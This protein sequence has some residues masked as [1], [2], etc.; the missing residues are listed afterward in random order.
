VAAKNKVENRARPGS[1][2]WPEPRPLPLPGGQGARWSGE[3]W[4]A[5]FGSPARIREWAAA[6]LATGRLLPWFAV[7]YGAGVVLYFSA[8]REPALWAA[9]VPTVVCAFVAVLLQRRIV[10]RNFVLGVI[11][12]GLFGIALG[13]AVVTLKTSLIGHPVLRFPASGVTVAGFVELREESQHTDRFVVRVDRIEGGRIDEMPRRVRLSV[14]RGMAP[15]PGSFVEVKASLDPPLQPLEPGSYDFARVFLRQSIP[16]RAQNISL[17]FLRLLAL[18]FGIAVPG[19][20]CLHK[21]QWVV[22]A[23][24]QFFAERYLF[25]IGHSAFSPMA[26]RRTVIDRFPS[27]CRRL[28]SVMVP[29]TAQSCQV[30]ALGGNRTPV[31]IEATDAPAPGAPRTESISAPAGPSGAQTNYSSLPVQCPLWLIHVRILG[32]KQTSRGH[33]P[34]SAFDPKRTLAFKTCCAAQSMLK[35]SGSSHSETSNLSGVDRRAA[36]GV[37]PSIEQQRPRQQCDK[38]IITCRPKLSS[39]YISFSGMSPGCCASVHTFGRGSGRWTASKHNAPSPLCTASV[40]SGSYSSFQASSA[41]CPRVSP[42][43]RPTATS[44]LVC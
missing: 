42:H 34:M 9:I 15:A 13:F 10:P 24:C 37:V 28:S 6:E 12:L 2:P 17:P 36:A 4:R 23:R 44:Q 20:H 18:Q 38:E 43:S 31:H 27:M 25:F 16:N 22:G 19:K 30:L 41:I 21:L 26:L 14:K 33:R 40:S 35:P 32:V 29:R 11:A 39:K 3:W 8:E 5:Q 7:A 1:I